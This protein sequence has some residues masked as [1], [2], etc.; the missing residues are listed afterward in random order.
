MKSLSLFS[1]L[2]K[3]ERELQGDESLDGTL[4]AEIERH[5]ANPIVSNGTA[6]HPDYPTEH[7]KNLSDRKWGKFRWLIPH[8]R[9][10]AY[11][12][13]VEAA[14]E[15]FHETDGFLTEGVTAFDNPLEPASAYP[16][17]V[18]A[19]GDTMRYLLPFVGIHVGQ[20]TIQAYEGIEPKAAIVTGLLG[21]W[22]GGRRAHEKWRRR[23]AAINK[24]SWLSKV[25]ERLYGRKESL[26]TQLERLASDMN[27][28]EV[29]DAAFME[30]IEKYKDNP[31]VAKSI[32]NS[33]Y[34]I[35]YINELYEKKW[36]EGYTFSPRFFS[37]LRPHKKDAAYNEELKTAREV[38]PDIDGFLTEGVIASDNPTGTLLKYGI[39]VLALGK[40]I[41]YAFPAFGVQPDGAAL[42]AYDALVESI[43]GA[44]GLWGIYRG[45]R[46]A[47]NKFSERQRT[48][49]QAE[50]LAKVFSRL[51]TQPAA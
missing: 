17:F 27:P 47:Y 15:I 43:S 1:K 32:A 6:G 33:N 49:E 16:L 12:A 19:I 8:K 51:Y 39:T 2:R 50:W 37:S 14:R 9:D 45:G 4:K 38:F 20:E 34:P 5:A 41:K 22:Q 31:I 35:E 30:T 46:R 23:K 40:G 44:A 36:E 24:A 25:F 10:K 3:L 13:E 28:G 18:Y 7:I 42:D 21:L 26:V 48:M 11:N 29:L